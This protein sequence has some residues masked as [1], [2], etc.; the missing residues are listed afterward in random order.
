MDNR[1][2][3][4]PSPD[5]GGNAPAPG[6]PGFSIPSQD[7]QAVRDDRRSKPLMYTIDLSSARSISAGTALALPLQGNVFYSDPL[8]DLSGNSVAG[9]AR[10]HFQDQSLNPVGTY[11]TV[12]PQFICKVPF[13]QLLV[14]NYA[15]P[16]KYLQVVYGVD[17]DVIPGLS[18]LTQTTIQGIVSA[19]EYGI[20]YGASYKST[21]SMAAN[22]PDTIFTPAANVSGAVLW[23]GSISTTAVSPYAGS[24]IAKASAPTTIIDGDVLASTESW[25][26]SATQNAFS[27]RFERPIRIAAGKGLYWIVNSAES[28]SNILQRAALYTLL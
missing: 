6:F 11:F 4:V 19:Q 7:F 2:L 9:V 15:Q 24:I 17:L 25:V 28:A 22:T 5:Q 21:T 18:N 23:R 8:Y 13:T 10:V 16:G 26:N 3:V 1:R 12:Q 20:T 14:E 27:F